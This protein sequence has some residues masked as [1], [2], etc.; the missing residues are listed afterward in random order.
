MKRFVIPAILVLCASTA[1]ALPQSFG[2]VKAFQKISSTVGG[3]GG[4]L[5]MADEFCWSIADLG[6]LDG[7]GVRD[8]AAG[9]LGDDDGGSNRGAVW[10]LFLN[11]GG[12]VRSKQKISDTQ[13]GFLGVLANGEFFGGSVAGLGD[14]DGDGVAD[15]AVGARYD[16]DGGSNLGAVW[17]LFLQAD[18]TVRAHYKIVNSDGTLGLYGHSLAAIGDLDGDGIRDLAVGTPVGIDGGLARGTVVILFLNA[19]GTVKAQQKINSSAGGFGGSL[20][21]SGWFGYS[22]AS[23]GDLDGDG[24]GDL[25]VG[26]AHDMDG[27]VNV[28]AVWI[29][30]LNPNGTVKTQQKINDSHGGFV[31]PLDTWD[32]YG[33]SVT[34]LGDVDGDG[35]GDLA[36]GAER[37]SDTGQQVGAAW[38][39]FLNPNG[40]VK[41]QQK[42]NELVGS[43]SGTLDPL[44]YFGSSLAGLGDVDGDGVEDLVVGAFSDD[45]GGGNRG[46]AWILFLHGDDQLPPLIRCPDQV[47]AV[48]AKTAPGAAVSFTVSATDGAGPAPALV[49]VPPSGSFFSRWTTLV[50]CTATDASGNS[51]VCTFPVVVQ[52]SIR[53]S[54]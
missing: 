54:P 22:L 35:V 13:G 6:D 19:D 10:I 12:T 8:L 1:N 29:L 50:T 23:L 14:L 30:F 33:S 9:A 17:I 26:T 27:S 2:T 21:D 28:G 18:G 7:D 34:S 46:A 48:C 49:C 11:Q 40:T 3:F 4:G 53:R 52:P 24:A 36:V 37:D 16:S 47:L 39:L 38:V 25:A 41:T 31:G 45:D 51:S 42:I 43:F 5:S 32:E 44:D 20:Y 15:L